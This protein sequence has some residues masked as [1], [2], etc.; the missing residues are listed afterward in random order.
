[1]KKSLTRQDFGNTRFRY[2]SAQDER[3]DKN[4]NSQGLVIKI[5]HL[6][7]NICGSSTILTGDCDAETWR[8][9][10]IED[11]SASDLKTSI[12][13]AGHHGSITFFDDPSDAENYYIDHMLII[14]P[15]MTIISV[16]D[17][18]HGHP[19]CENMDI[20][21]FCTSINFLFLFI[22]NFPKSG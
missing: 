1:M 8:Y 10:I 22:F 12:L 3:L 20:E 15:A 4:A 9:A 17:N 21:R 2:L 7:Q 11:Y 5:E 18:P 6:N 16:G 14:Q 13:M 19:Y